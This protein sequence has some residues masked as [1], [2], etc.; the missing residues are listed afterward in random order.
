MSKQRLLV[1]QSL[2]AMERQHP[3]GFERS[4]EDNLRLIKEA[5]FDDITAP[6]VNP[7]RVAHI[8]RALT[9]S[10]LAVESACYPQTV[11]DLKPAVELAQRLGAL[12]LN[13]QAD[14]RPRRVK[15]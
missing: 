6:C 4:I 5:G 14:V 13:I 3:D 9:G 1:L 7:A 10:G 12:H 8:A 11:D 15:D 2:W